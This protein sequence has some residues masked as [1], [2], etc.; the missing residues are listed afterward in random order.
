VALFPAGRPADGAPLSFGHSLMA[1]GGGRTRASCQ[2]DELSSLAGVAGRLPAGR[3]SIR[4]GQLGHGARAT[5]AGHLGR[6][7]IA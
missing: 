4:S 3:V 1:G 7:R 6:Q 2:L 5:C